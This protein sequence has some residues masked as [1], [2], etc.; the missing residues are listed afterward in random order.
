MPNKLISDL[1]LASAVGTSVAPVSNAAG[2]TTSK[3]TLADIAALGG[4]APADN[5]VTTA[6]LAN[7]A[8]T[9]AKIQ[10]VSATDRLLGRATAGAGVLE[11]ITCTAFGR[12]V[13]AAAD[14]VAGR[15]ALG[16][17]SM[18]TQAASS[19]AVLGGTINGAT[20]GATTPATGVFTTVTTTGN[21]GV[22][23][24][25]PAD[26][27]AVNGAISPQ[28]ITTTPTWDT[29]TRFW[30]ESGVGARYDG[31]SHRF[32]VGAARAAALFISSGGAV[33]LGTTSPTGR[34]HMS[35]PAV[36]DFALITGAGS[37]SLQFRPNASLG[38]NNSLVQAGDSSIIYSG[39]SINTG[40]LSI[41]PWASGTSGMRLTS[42][43]D[44]GVGTAAPQTRMHIYN[45][46][47]S[48]PLL[49]ETGGNYS[50]LRLADS[51]GYSTIV[52]YGGGLAFQQNGISRIWFTDAG[53]VGIG[54]VSPAAR[55]DVDGAAIVS[56]LTVRTAMAGAIP[57]ATAEGR[58]TLSS[59]NPV[60]SGD[61]TNAATLYYTPAVGN[62]IA[63][64][65]TTAARWQLFTFSE[66]S[67]ALTGLTSGTNYDVFVFDNNGT[68]TLSTTAWT[69][70]TT[71]VALSRQNGVLVSSTAA[72]RRYVGTI[73]TSG[74]GVCEDST[75]QRFVWN[76]DNKVPRQMVMFDS[77]LHTY[78]N[79]INTY[80]PWRNSTALG[81]TRTAFVTGEHGP[82]SLVS[83][84]LYT[85][86]MQAQAGLGIDLTNN[87]SP[88]VVIYHNLT[89]NTTISAM[90]HAYA[91][92][93]YHFVQAVQSGIG[94]AT[95]TF[96]SLYATPVF[97]G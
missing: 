63:L 77:T 8:V 30:A 2:T 24:S 25:S 37:R 79:T 66:L 26:R 94:A 47:A 3:V 29:N 53:N 54:A 50:A 52:G 14:A 28:P 83:L 4:G 31:F 60:P 84:A 93:G 62:K 95:S 41:V 88:G 80:R 27:L 97:M 70:D 13:L 90:Q 22:G 5:S 33:G 75:S 16:L 92:A 61:I 46:A 9:Y 44:V 64:Y 48:E 57:V 43:G 51:T 36:D 45:S 21:V 6:K 89:L 86:T 55:L 56:T 10:N 91:P 18:A 87:F 42:T 78:S 96:L 49:V 71:R 32:D 19:V 20:I 34:V 81:V 35:F 12:S 17:G 76:N 15:T 82:G 85:Q 74:I 39:G 38:A 7:S 58:L 59:N 68:L 73:R 40:A 1:P 72:N 69:N 23:V 65:A 11:E 67:L